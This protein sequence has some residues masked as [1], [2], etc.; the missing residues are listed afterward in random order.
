MQAKAKP[1]IFGAVVGIIILAVLLNYVFNE[2]FS[3]RGNFIKRVYV[4]DALVKAEIVKSK[5]KIEQ[6]LAGRKKLADGR[7]MMFEMPQNREQ[8]FWM[9]GVLFPIDI[10]WIQNGKVTGCEKNISPQD[11]RIFASPGSASFILEV[12]EGFCDQHGV[13]VND[14]VKM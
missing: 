10:I 4:R 3:A 11:E 7:G 14:E 13:E 2:V 8:H 6:G 5:E 12:P 1:K 9:K